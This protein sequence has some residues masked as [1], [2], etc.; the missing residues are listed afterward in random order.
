MDT[1]AGP[2]SN[3]KVTGCSGL[4]AAIESGVAMRIH[5]YTLSWN[6][7]KM[8]GF[9]FRHYDPLVERYVFFDDG[10]NDGTLD[11]LHNHP[12]VEVRRFERDTADSFVLSSKHLNNHVW[13]ESRGI[14]DWVIVSAID[15]HFYHRDLTGYLESARRA[16]VTAIPGLGYEMVSSIF[17]GPTE[18]LTRTRTLGVPEPMWNKLNLFNPDAVEE[19]DYSVGRH[20]AKPSGRIIYPEID[21]LLILHYKYIGFEYVRP[22]YSLLK[23]GLGV[24]DRKNRW[25]YQFDYD[26]SE[27]SHKIAEL[28]KHAIDIASLVEPGQYHSGARWWRSNSPSVIL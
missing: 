23:T 11:V 19:T 7:M 21:E 5:L 16:G 20:E 8:L 25:G 12:R 9:F 1:L 27:I 22:R 4:T 18:E 14:A 17:P 10:S 13:K 3:K 26:D 28:E 6:E 24:T 2:R 15:E